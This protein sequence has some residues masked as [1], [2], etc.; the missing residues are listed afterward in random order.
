M[1]SNLRNLSR[2]QH[3][4]G[5]KDG[6]AA[7]SSSLRRLEP[8][9]HRVTHKAGPTAGSEFNASPRVRIQCKSPSSDRLSCAKPSA[10]R[11]LQKFAKKKTDFGKTSCK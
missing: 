7:L 5:C 9:T 6:F 8:A 4:S 3:C 11:T 1:S 10:P 2:R